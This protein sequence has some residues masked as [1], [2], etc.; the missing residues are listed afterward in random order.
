MAVKGLDNVL[1]NLNAEIKGI[2]GRTLDGVLAAGLLVQ[3]RAQQITPVDTGALRASAQTIPVTTKQGPAAEV[4]YSQNYA[5][6]VHENLEANFKEG[7]PKF[8]ERALNESAGDVVRIIEEKAR[9]Q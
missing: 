4:G 1:R 2:E 9:V 5:L 8:L 3:R 7:G 6:Y